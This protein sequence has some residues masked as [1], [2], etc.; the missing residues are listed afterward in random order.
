MRINNETTA[1]AWRIFLLKKCM[2][3]TQRW[4]SVSGKGFPRKR[5]GEVPKEKERGSRKLR[6][7]VCIS[8][9]CWRKIQYKSDSLFLSLEKLPESCKKKANFVHGLYKD[10]MCGRKARTNKNL[11]EYGWQPW[12]RKEKK[13]IKKSVLS[14]SSRQCET[15]SKTLGRKFINP[16][17]GYPAD[18]HRMSE[19]WRGC[20][21][22]PWTFHQSIDK[23]HLIIIIGRTENQHNA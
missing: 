14:F 10:D 12:F 4:N 13:N 2:S 3:I 5:R 1:R 21:K 22:G 9:I 11:T 6:P 16:T 23:F 17:G 7:P 15:G 20:Q 19:W 8:S 18:I